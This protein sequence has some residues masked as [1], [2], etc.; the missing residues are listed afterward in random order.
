MV[1]EKTSWDGSRLRYARQR[2]NGEELRGRTGSWTLHDDVETVARGIWQEVLDFIVCG[3]PLNALDSVLQLQPV[4]R[5]LEAGFRI[6][7]DLVRRRQR[8]RS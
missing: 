2:C 1:A 3:Q 6:D 7:V 5:V 8:Q 4:Q